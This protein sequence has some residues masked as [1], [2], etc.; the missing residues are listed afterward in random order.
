MNPPVS[1]YSD[2]VCHLGEGPSAHPLRGSLFWFDVLERRI[3]ERPFDGGATTVHDLPFHGS[4]AAV[5]DAD[6]HLI[7]SDQ[8]LHVR[9]IATGDLTLLS[10]H[11][12]DDRETRSNDGRVHP[13]GALWFST[14]RWDVAMGAAAIWWF[15]GGEIRR[16]L[17]ETPLAIPNGIAFAPDGSHALFAC[18]VAGQ[19]WR[20][21]TDP[22]TGLPSAEPKPFAKVTDGGP[23]GA[24]VDADGLYWNARWG[25]A[26]L[27]A[28]D[29]SG[30]RIRSIPLPALQTSCPAFV[31]PDA[32]RIA[33]T[34]AWEGMDDAARAA[35][36]LAGRTFL[37]DM[38]VAGRFDPPVAMG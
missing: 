10:A 30:T 38:P 4:I 12:A 9:T 17:A 1:V 18:S 13:S 14:M 11:L 7:V 8:G 2:H 16:I 33:V 32:D 37:I 25:G 5:I 24:I 28:Y 35:D 20:V 23:D 36:P 31:G 15:R 19:I 26:A 3:L 22:A 34:S 27:D 21:E 29:A 6:R